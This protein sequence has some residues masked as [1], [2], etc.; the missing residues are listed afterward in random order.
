MSARHTGGFAEQTYRAAELFKANALLADDSLFTPGTPIWTPELLGRIHTRFLNRPDE[1][2]GGFW[3]KLREQLAGNFPEVYQLMGEALY[4]HYLIL[5]MRIDTKRRNIGGRPR[6]KREVADATNVIE[7][8]PAPVTIPPELDAGLQSRFI[9]PG[10]NNRQIPYQVG[11]LIETVEQWKELPA[12]RWE[13]LLEAPWAFKDFLNGVEFRSRLLVNNQNRGDVERH[14]LLHILFPDYFES[15]LA[16]DKNGIAGS[17][18]F[19][20]FVAEPTEDVDRQIYQIRQGLEAELGSSFSFYNTPV[21]ERWRGVSNDIPV[22]PPPT[23]TAPPPMEG[24]QAL[25]A[26]LY[27]PDDTFLKEIQSLL[28]EKRQVIFQG[29]PGTG[30]TYVA[31]KLALHLAGSAERVSLVQF[32]PSY[33]YE[34]FVQGFR[35]TLKNGQAGFEL[36]KGPLLEIAEKAGGSEKPHYLIIDEINRGNLATVFGELYFLLE[37][38]GEKMRLQYSDKGEEFAL[39]KNL[40]I[41]GT[42]NT[43]DRSIAMVDLALRRR[44]YFVEFHPE[45][46]PVKEVL[47]EWLRQHANDMRW[48]AAVVDKAN[49]LLKDSDAAIGPSYFMREGLDEAGVKRIW[50]HSVLPYIAERL[51]NDR[52]RLAEFDLE[53]LIKAVSGGAGDGN[54]PGPDEGDGNAGGGVEE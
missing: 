5:D 46:E 19:A 39:P 34:D 4:L 45:K 8:W 25:A 40:F 16:G 7:W 21:V 33:A 35:P 51:F 13:G 43:A 52:E 20:S 1:G 14:L 41:I 2:D 23:G 11:T 15:S 22:A 32:H 49:E 29:P 54:V 50:E 10:N 18:N 37:Y 12:D 26:E 31:Q 42:M 48:V 24:L 44:F 28:A 3:G 36:R 6:Y 9:K 17:A 47:R 38:R 27:L 53:K 30:K